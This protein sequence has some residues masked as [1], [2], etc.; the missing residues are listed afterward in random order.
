MDDSGLR[1]FILVTTPAESTRRWIHDQ[2]RGP[3]V[4]IGALHGLLGHLEVQTDVFV[5]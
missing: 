2:H 3:R 5:V 4:N 1:I